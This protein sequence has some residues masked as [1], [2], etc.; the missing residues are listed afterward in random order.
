MTRDKIDTVSIRSYFSNLVNLSFFD[1]GKEK[2]REAAEYLTEMLTEFARSESLYKLTD[3]AGK[4]VSTIVDMLIESR[5]VPAENSGYER[6]VRKY[7]GDFSLFMSGMFR[8]YVNRGSYLSY[9][10]SEGMKSY[11]VVS[12]LDL[13]RGDGN[14]IMFSRLSREFEFYSG[15]LDYMRKVY[16][17]PDMSADPFSNIALQISRMEH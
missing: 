8:D 1:L 6:E 12:I 3:A 5:K 4:K 14:P 9:Y 7:M 16:F 15:A 17:G 11:S 13:E 2:D 10:M